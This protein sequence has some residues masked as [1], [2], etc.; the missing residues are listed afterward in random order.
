LLVS[1]C[2]TNAFTDPPNARLQQIAEQLP[3]RL[4]LPKPGSVNLRARRLIA[5]HQAL[6][7]HDLEELQNRRVLRAS[8]H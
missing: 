3:L 8:I 7:R 2:R 1:A 5:L 4:L 6:L